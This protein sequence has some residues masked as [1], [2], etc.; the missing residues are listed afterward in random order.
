ML[1]S[2]SLLSNEQWNG[3]NK[4]KIRR[5][6]DMIGVLMAETFD[7][8]K[9]NNMKYLLIFNTQQWSLTYEI[10]SKTDIITRLLR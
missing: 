5:R 2:L 1:L 8:P 6:W 4:T 3:S 10:L 7:M 9:E